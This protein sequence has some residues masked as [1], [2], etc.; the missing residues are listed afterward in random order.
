MSRE[1]Y[2]GNDFIKKLVRDELGFLVFPIQLTCLSF[3]WLNVC[4]LRCRLCRRQLEREWYSRIFIISY[5][6]IKSEPKVRI[7]NKINVAHYQTGEK[8][9]GTREQSHPLFEYFPFIKGDLT[10]NRSREHGNILFFHFRGC[11]TIQLSRDF[12]DT[13]WTDI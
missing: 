13:L 4:S 2:T 3:T 1:R 11:L 9:R 5:G 8:P 10:K 7:V 12:F 6:W